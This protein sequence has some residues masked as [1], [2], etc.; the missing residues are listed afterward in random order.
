MPFHASGMPTGFVKGVT[1]LGDA[2]RARPSA[3]PCALNKGQ[4]RHRSLA[5]G[6]SLE[7]I[8]RGAPEEDR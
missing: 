3:V 4:V 2:G 5:G 7:G 8:A 6:S 1:Y